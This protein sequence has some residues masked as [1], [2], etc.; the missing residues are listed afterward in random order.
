MGVIGVRAGFQSA[1]R[2]MA[3][4]A[5]AVR[6]CAGRGSQVRQPWHGPEDKQVELLLL[7]GQINAAPA[8]Q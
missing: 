8:L 7:R 5:G 6:W 2:S 1:N 3:S 4:S